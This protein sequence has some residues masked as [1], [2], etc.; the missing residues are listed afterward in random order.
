NAADIVAL[1][2][3]ITPS[4][5]EMAHVAA[6]MERQGFT[7]PL[8]VG[9]ATTSK[10]HTALKIAPHYSGQVVHSADASL[11]AGVFNEL[12]AKN[13]PAPAAAAT[14]AATA[15]AAKDTGH[16]TPDAA[17]TTAAPAAAAPAPAAAAP[18]AAAPAPAAAAPAPAAAAALLPLAAAR[19][20][21]FRPDFLRYPPMPPRQTDVF[22]LTPTIAD[23]RPFIDWRMFFYTWSLRGAPP[24]I[25]A[26]PKQGTAARQLYDDAQA[27]LDTLARDPQICPRAVFGIFPVRREGD[28]AAIFAD[29]AR[30]TRLATLHFLR[31]QKPETA[32][33]VPASATSPSTSAPDASAPCLSLADFLSPDADWLGAF[34]ATSGTALDALARAA[35]AANDDYKSILLQSLADRLAEA[36]A[37]WLHLR[38]RREYWATA[39]AE[40]LS[41]E[42]CLAAKYTGIRPAVGYPSLPDHTE[43]STFWHLLDAQTRTGISLTEH[44]AMSPAASVSGLYFAHP[45]SRYF[46]IGPIAEDQLADYAHRKNLPLPEAR[47]WL[48]QNL[49]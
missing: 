34:A 24:R 21:A 5:E 14:A 36:A 37:E 6:E 29:P 47:K 20:R 38:V 43:K 41:P 7:I 40:N 3:L 4:L 44:Y 45:Q 18:A 8:A 12:L 28:S 27:A 9:G 16:G 49:G 31:R 25:F 19:A 39:P 42:E 1:S 13:I 22:T 46:S 17:T 32:A 35:K 23:L 48:S 15:Y 30:Q 11:V 10:T 26:D 2:G 33:V